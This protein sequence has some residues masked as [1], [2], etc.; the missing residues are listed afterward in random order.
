MTPQDKRGEYIDRRWEHIARRYGAGVY[1]YPYMEKVARQI[2]QLEWEV[3]NPASKPRSKFLRLAAIALCAIGIVAGLGEAWLWVCPQS[4]GFLPAPEHYMPKVFQ[5][6]SGWTLRPNTSSRHDHIAGDFHVTVTIDANGFRQTRP[7][8][9]DKPTLLIMGDSFTFGFG[10]EDG[11]T[12]PAL[13]AGMITNRNVIN[14]G[15]VG[16]MALNTQLAWV[17]QN[18]HT[19]R[20]ETVVY[21]FFSG[22]DFDDIAAGNQYYADD[23]GQLRFCRKGATGALTAWMRQHSRLAAVVMDR[24]GAFLPA[25]PPDSGLLQAKLLV[26]EAAVHA[27]ENGYEAVFLFAP[28]TY[29]RAEPYTDKREAELRRQIVAEER[30]VC[31]ALDNL[32]QEDKSRLHFEHDGH[33]TPYGHAIVAEKLAEWLQ[34]KSGEQR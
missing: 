24:V 22:N 29:G 26:H 34:A 32:W 17:R 9:A 8:V 19:W 3:Q 20:P 10:V 28:N 4:V 33:W 18:Y 13:L 12:Y 2:A 14:G 15:Y 21:Q 30:L 7:I 23:I 1:D 31:I 5:P 25:S 27:R 16:G 11:E 6:I